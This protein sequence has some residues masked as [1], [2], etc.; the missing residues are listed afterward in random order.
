MNY[1]ELK[2]SLPSAVH[3]YYG[4][5]P[6]VLSSLTVDAWFGQSQGIYYCGTLEP[7]ASL[8]ALEVLNPAAV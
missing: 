6:A 1:D 4:I 3:F 5:D 8:A 2:N 7:V